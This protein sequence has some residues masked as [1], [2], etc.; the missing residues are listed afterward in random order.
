MAEEGEDELVQSDSEDEDYVPEGDEDDVITDEEALIKEEKKTKL[1]RGR[2]RSGPTRKR[3]S[4]SKRRRRGGIKLPDNV[5]SS[6]EDEEEYDDQSSSNDDNN[7]SNEHD[8]EG[9]GGDSNEGNI[10]NT[11]EEQKKAKIDEL[12]AEF[13]SSVNPSPSSSHVNA[14]PEAPPNRQDTSVTSCDVIEPKIIKTSYDFAGE[15][16]IVEKKVSQKLTKAN[17]SQDKEKKNPPVVKRTGG[18]LALLSSLTKKPKMTTLDKS[19]LDWEKFKEKAN[20]KDELQF[21]AKDGYL[22][23]QEFL[24]RVDAKQFELEKQERL[25]RFKTLY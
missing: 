18:A 6:E 24:Q 8:N 1:K 20:L 23:R 7:D 19:K 21:Q 12:W 22:E 4:I 15:E 10:V 2:K 13:K 16:V 17:E 25:K 9:E 14:K 11:E 3:Q 5:T